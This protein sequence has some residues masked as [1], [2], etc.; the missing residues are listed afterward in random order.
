VRVIKYYVR[1]QIHSEFKYRRPWSFSLH[2][3]ERTC[4]WNYFIPIPRLDYERLIAIPTESFV[5]MQRCIAD[6]Y[7]AKPWVVRQ[8]ARH[9]VADMSRNGQEGREK[10]WI[11][12][13]WEYALSSSCATFAC[14]DSH[15]ITPR[16][17]SPCARTATRKILTKRI[18][19]LP[20]TNDKLD[21][22]VET[23][24]K[25]RRSENWIQ[26]GEKRELPRA[27]ARSCQGSLFNIASI[28]TQIFLAV[29]KRVS[30]FTFNVVWLLA[31]ESAKVQAL[32]KEN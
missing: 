16:N 2:R 6:F 23:I 10:L 3:N 8:H 20:R 31:Y 1:Y 29:A 30:V 27:P 28:I 11:N 12:S 22:D 17:A 32:S 4:P 5:F 18:Q 19:D 21:P 25:R 24:G 14:R 9:N 13:S 26:R 7:H 15:E